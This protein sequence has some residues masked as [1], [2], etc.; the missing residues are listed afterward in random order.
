[1]NQYKKAASRE[2]MALSKVVGIRLT[3]VR[4][5][6]ARARL[7]TARDLSKATKKFFLRVA[8]LQNAQAKINHGSKMAAAK[9]HTERAAVQRA[10]GD[11]SAQLNMLANIIVAT[12]H[13]YGQALKRLTKVHQSVAKQTKFD[14]RMFQEQV[15]AMQADMNMALVRS[16]N[17]GEARGKA[18]SDRLAIKHKGT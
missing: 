8:A 17:I 11:F 12:S 13:Q 1:M 2:L 16:V 18:D 10:R 5:A 7:E 9:I 3:K 15:A 14:Q 6:Q 4:S